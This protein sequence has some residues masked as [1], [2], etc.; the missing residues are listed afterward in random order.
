MT[1]FRDSHRLAS[2]VLVDANEAPLGQLAPIRLSTPWFQEIAELVQAVRQQYNINI[3]ILRLLQVDDSHL[4][5][6]EVS[7]LAEV[8]PRTITS[9]ELLPRKGNLHEHP[10]RLPYARAGGPDLDLTWANNALIEAGFGSV[11]DQQQIRTWNLSSI[12]KLNTA[13]DTFWLKSVPP[14]FAHEGK[15]LRL[16]KR[17]KVPRLVAADQQHILMQ[18]LPGEDCYDAGVE[19]MLHM[20]GS[21]VELQWQWRDRLSELSEA[22]LP[23]WHA[24]FLGKK[25]PAVIHRYMDKLSESHQ[26]I[27][28][29]FESDLPSRLSQLEDCGIP[30]TLVHGDYHPGNWR[31]TG[32]DLTILDWG[33]CFIGHPL[34]DHPAL[35]DRAGDHADQL[36]SHWQSLWQAKLPNADIARAFD[37]IAPVATARMAVVFKGFLDNIEPNERIY[38]DTDPVLALQKTAGI[39][40]EAEYD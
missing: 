39:L 19:Q 15:A 14:F 17:E 33:D 30:S 10:L 36:L 24:E 22:G 4:P 18:H 3:T 31:G 7:Y 38:H 40:A 34:L 2:A 37:L 5:E 35:I 20:V 1:E 25:I 6:I 28:S 26:S 16:F 12:W 21:L 23:D 8:D 32:T 9:I 11:I 29:K 13:S 27:L